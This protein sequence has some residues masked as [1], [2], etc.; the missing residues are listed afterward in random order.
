[1]EWIGLILQIILLGTFL[2]WEGYNK[3][4][5]ENQALK[6]DSRD[7]NYE[8]EKGKNLATKEDIAHITQQIESVKDSYNKALEAHKIELQKE[9]EYHKYIMGL[10]QSLDRMLLHNI[11]LCL[12]AG[13]E[14]HIGFLE[15]DESLLVA[16]SKSFTRTDSI[17][18]Y[19]SV[20]FINFKKNDNRIIKLSDNPKL[21]FKSYK[22]LASLKKLIL[23][24]KDKSILYSN[25]NIIAQKGILL[26]NYHPWKYLGGLSTNYKIANGKIDVKI[27]LPELSNNIP[28]LYHIN[29]AD[30]H[31][32]LVPYIK[33]EYLNH[34]NNLFPKYE[35]LANFLRG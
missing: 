13:V 3:K 4:K 26:L 32:N 11:A 20:Y 2:F 7:I 12:N 16:N 17:D 33:A 14:E 29:C 5:G 19:M 15:S 22:E 34:L 9:F 1:M 23:I 24:D 18:D 30:I 10:C 25:L 31:K 35:E 28:V 8:G 27:E 6:E 21:K